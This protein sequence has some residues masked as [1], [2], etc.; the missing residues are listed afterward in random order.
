MAENGKIYSAIANVMAD[1]G[2]VTKSKKNTQ[3]AGFMYRGIDDV[4]NALNPA[5]AKHKIFVVPEI[6]EQIRE[7]R[8]TAKG[9]S[10]IYSLCKIKYTFFA[11]D[12]S[13]VSATVIGEAMDS[14]DKATNKSMSIAFKYACFQIFCIPTEEMLDPD[15]EVHDISQKRTGSAK[16]ATSTQQQKTK[17]IEKQKDIPNQAEIAKQPIGQAKIKLIK[18]ELERTGVSENAILTRYKVTKVEEITEE[19]FIKVASAL[20]NTPT[21]EK[22]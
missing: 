12:G 15:S 10:I 19:L 16:K 20:K 9:Y 14:G 21:K 2:A 22:K 1:V 7:D 8:T 3:G 13:N 5:M 11:E 17:P 6:L 4:M 18:S